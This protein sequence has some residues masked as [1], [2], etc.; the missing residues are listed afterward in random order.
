MQPLARTNPYCRV[1]ILGDQ[2]AV[3]G[4]VRTVIGAHRCAEADLVVVPDLAILHDVDALA[5]NVDLA[6]SFLY[7]VSLGVDITTTA[8]LVAVQGYP[9]QFPPSHCVRHV[10]A[11][12]G[13]VKLCVEPKLVEEHRD[14]YNALRRIARVSGSKCSVSKTSRDPASGGIV[15]RVLRDV[16]AW[17]CSARRIVNVRGPKVFSADGVALPT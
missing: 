3:S 4:P 2:C 9:R 15:L 16:V 13:A 12:G 6:V 5:A 11:S 10:P 1:T 17:A 7:I 14:V 8:Q